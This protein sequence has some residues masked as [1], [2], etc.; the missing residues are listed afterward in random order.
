MAACAHDL[1]LERLEEVPLDVD[2]RQTIDDGHSVDL[3][4]VLR[5]DVLPAQ[6]LEDRGADLDAIAVAE[7][8]LAHDLLVVHVR[9]VGRSVVHAPPRAA[10]LLEVRVAARHAV[11]LE[12]D[13]VLGAAADANGARV[14]HEASSEERR[15]LRVDDHEA[16]VA[17]RDS[18]GPLE[19]LLHDGCDSSFLLGLA[20]A[21]G[22][23]ALLVQP[24]E[25]LAVFS[26]LW[27]T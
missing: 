19:G 22:L 24:R 16:V 15:L 17:L 8:R 2:L 14:E 1:L 12:D 13:M 6:E 25:L 4:V 7:V 20:H 23:T 5:L 27:L 26:T 9:P 3:F 18:I 11:A 10:A 21:C